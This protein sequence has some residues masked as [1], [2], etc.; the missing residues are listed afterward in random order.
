[1]CESDIET[2][3]TEFEYGTLSNTAVIALI[4]RLV[5]SRQAW[6]LQGRY[7]RLA[8]DLIEKGLI[9]PAHGLDRLVVDRL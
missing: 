2:A 5:D 7:G 9:R 1:M 4:Q 6:Q 8:V 3:I